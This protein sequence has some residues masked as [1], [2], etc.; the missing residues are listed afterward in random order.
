MLIL[1]G[2]IR[3]VLILHHHFVFQSAIDPSQSWKAVRL[4]LVL[5]GDSE[6]TPSSEGTC[7]HQHVRQQETHGDGSDLGKAMHL[8]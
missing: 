8:E 5:G 1:Q 2:P 3:V 7:L 6:S 4:L